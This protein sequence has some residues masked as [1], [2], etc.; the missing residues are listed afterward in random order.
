MLIPLNSLG[1]L[2]QQHERVLID[3]SINHIFNFNYNFYTRGP[4]HITIL[5][6][7]L[8][9]SIQ[10][11]MSVSGQALQALTIPAR[12]RLVGFKPFRHLFP[13][14]LSSSMSRHHTTP[15]ETDK[16]CSFSLQIK[17]VRKGPNTASVENAS[18]SSLRMFQALQP[19]IPTYATN[20]CV[21]ASHH[22]AEN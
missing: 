17:P 1:I 7:I 22:I 13:P 20:L 4:H 12:H 8:S 2:S 19:F 6:C 21:K 16:S 5:L 3:K 15:H 9:L 11:N 10:S 18:S 14:M